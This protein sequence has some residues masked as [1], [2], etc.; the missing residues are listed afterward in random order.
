[1][2]ARARRDVFRVPLQELTMEERFAFSHTMSWEVIARIYNAVSSRYGAE[3]KKLVE[4]CI[5]GYM[6][7]MTPKIARSLG[8]EGSDMESVLKVI[9]WHDVNL[10][11]L[12]EEE[13]A[14]VDHNEGVLRI[15]SCFLKDR[16]TPRDCKLG[17]PWVEGM[18]EGI[19]PRIKYKATK[20]LTRGDDC[21]ELV[22]RLEEG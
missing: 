5:R 7:E 11:P 18:L 8:I 3:G 21:C 19:N 13:I 4:D 1:M 20:V 6:R 14:R 22:M 10:W 12:M 9:N 2:S 17:I 16:W 15:T